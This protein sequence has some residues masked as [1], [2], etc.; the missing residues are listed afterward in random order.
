SP[1]QAVAVECVV[2]MTPRQASNEP[3]EFVEAVT[4]LVPDG[5][6]VANIMES[7]FEAVLV[8]VTYP[9]EVF[10]ILQ[11][12]AAKRRM[13]YARQRPYGLCGTYADFCKQTV[14]GARIL[15]SA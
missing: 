5:I 1:V 12:G 2:S 13:G 3:F 8:Q 6:K 9:V 7:Y 14:D 10:A 15:V 11:R 4:Y